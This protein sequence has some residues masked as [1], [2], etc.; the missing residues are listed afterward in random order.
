MSKNVKGENERKRI[1]ERE[2]EQERER[3]RNKDQMHQ[4]FIE[5]I[6]LKSIKLSMAGKT[7][8]WYKF[9]HLHIQET[10]KPFELVM[11]ALRNR[12]LSSWHKK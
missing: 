5:I 7:W 2:R 1:R 11:A 12:L 8:H 4:T 6:L 9:V 3:E 10:H